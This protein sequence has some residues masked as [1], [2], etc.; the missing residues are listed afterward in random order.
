MPGP[1]KTF[2]RK[3]LY[4]ALAESMMELPEEQRAVF[5]RHELEGYSFREISA[6]T[7]VPVNTL[8]ARKRYAVLFLRKRLKMLKELMESEI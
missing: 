5:I 6:K 7:G 3:I 4:E 2:Y 1:E 8:L